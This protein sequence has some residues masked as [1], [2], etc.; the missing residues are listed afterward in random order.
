[1]VEKA[2]AATVDRR[3]TLHV[4]KHI[5]IGHNY[6]GNK[7]AIAVETDRGPVVL[8]LSPDL[9]SEHTK[10]CIDLM[11]MLDDATL[12]TMKGARNGK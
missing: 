1:M 6:A 3:P 4:L 2:K 5:D 10:L 12:S 9:L 11:D 8:V 7:T